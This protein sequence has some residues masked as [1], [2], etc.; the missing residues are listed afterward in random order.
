[1][2]YLVYVYEMFDVCVVVTICFLP[3]LI[4]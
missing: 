4:P 2:I 1:L 3:V